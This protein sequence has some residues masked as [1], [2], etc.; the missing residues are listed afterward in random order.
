MRQRLVD[1]HALFG[2]SLQRRALGAQP[3]GQRR[4]HVVR[5]LA[6]PQAQPSGRHMVG[7]GRA[8]RSEVALHSVL[9]LPLR[10]N[11]KP[12]CYPADFGVWD[13]DIVHS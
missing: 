4:Q 10:A 1:S 5:E 8:S 7:E 11:L 2:D 12:G 9:A 3:R 6:Q 13:K